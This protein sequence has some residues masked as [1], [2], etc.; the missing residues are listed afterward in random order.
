M[1]MGASGDVQGLVFDIDTFAVHDGPGIR[2][3][4]YLKGC[5]LAC[6]WCH[7]PESQCA[8]P[9]LAFAADRCTLCGRCAAAC[10]RSVHCV[11][12]LGHSIERERCIACGECAAQCPSGALTIKG[13]WVSA[14]DVVA[15]A[16]RLKPFFDH[17]GGGITLTG[18]EVTGQV[19]FAE[20]VLA[21]CRSR[22]IHTAIETCGACS[23]PRLQRLVEQADLA[24]YDLKLLDD[25][26][27]RRWTGASNQQIL[28]NARRLAPYD[29]RVRVPL[30]PGITDT[31]E[32]LRAIFGF[33]R[34][35]GLER[36]A[37]LPYNASAGAKYEW[38][39]RAYELEG[40]PQSEE[41]LAAM[42]SLAGEMGP[43]AGIG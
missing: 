40:E 23:W 43:E 36:V 39:G 11:G 38:L 24:L 21:G 37:L 16:V 25:D 28:D 34:D 42:V 5:P 27:H 9:E 20:A 35:A 17:S 8:E 12:E 6:R 14:A 33:M 32:N 15:R 19:E 30:I 7:S 18:G 29:V 4:V 22:G 41:R 10:S 3:A 1:V 2:L 26:A 13:N 31:E